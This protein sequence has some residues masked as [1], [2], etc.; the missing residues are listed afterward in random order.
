M[1]CFCTD[2]FP[3]MRPLKSASMPARR[4]APEARPRHDRCAHPT[5]DFRGDLGM[6]DP[7]LPPFV[8]QGWHTCTLFSRPF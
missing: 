5:T 6:P 8:E 1:W 4:I 2:K 7:N 3:V